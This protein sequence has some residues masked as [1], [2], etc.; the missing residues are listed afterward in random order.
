[1]VV[2]RLRSVVNPDGLGATRDAGVDDAGGRQALEAV[3]QGYAARVLHQPL[4]SNGAAGNLAAA[5]LDAGRIAGWD[6]AS[7]SV[8]PRRPADS[9][10]VAT[11]A[12]VG[13][14]QSATPG[15]C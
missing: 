12:G 3:R 9:D 5:T 4:Q 14:D 15:T 10:R 8:W 7:C 11:R 13:V 2:N 6:S 1:M